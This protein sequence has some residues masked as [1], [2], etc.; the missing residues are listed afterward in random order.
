MPPFVG[1]F[2]SCVTRSVLYR[3]MG[4]RNDIFEEAK[5]VVSSSR[6]VCRT[7]GKCSCGF[8]SCKYC[9]VR[10]C[11]CTCALQTAVRFWGWGWRQY[12]RVYNARFSRFTCRAPR[13]HWGKVSARCLIRSLLQLYPCNASHV[14]VFCPRLPPSAQLD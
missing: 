11:R 7:L 4:I 12:L 2:W 8:W 6:E 9:I 1:V 13:G 5:R 3:K 10:C 14:R